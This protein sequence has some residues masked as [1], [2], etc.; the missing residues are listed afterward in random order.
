MSSQHN[1]LA[2]I[3]L[4]CLTL[5]FVAEWSMLSIRENKIEKAVEELLTA[6]SDASLQRIIRIGRN[7]QQSL[8]WEHKK[9]FEY[10]GVMYDVISVFESDDS[11]DYLCRLDLDETAVKK[12]M[13]HLLSETKAQYPK[14]RSLQTQIFHFFHSLIAPIPGLSEQIDIGSTPLVSACPSLVIGRLANAPSTPPPKLSDKI[15]NI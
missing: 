7:D 13:H 6:G 2:I 9:E 14:N 4:G 3:L 11:I 5:P 8:K 12:K 15:S 1:I 10:Q